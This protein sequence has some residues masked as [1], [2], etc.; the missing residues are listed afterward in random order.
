MSFSLML[1]VCPR[2]RASERGVPRPRGMCTSALLSVPFSCHAACQPLG[3]WR[4]GSSETIGRPGHT[5]TRSVSGRRADRTGAC[6]GAPSS[7]P[8]RFPWRGHWDETFLVRTIT[9]FP[10]AGYGACTVRNPC[11]DGCGQGAGR[12]RSLAPF[13]NP[14]TGRP[15]YPG[16]LTEKPKD[17]I[18][19]FP[20]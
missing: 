17:K 4:A 16:P 10:A 9:S 20:I 19:T 1:G 12:Q 2:A 18:G 3:D 13:V 7:Y 5:H 15:P 11:E 6:T 8:P 14:I